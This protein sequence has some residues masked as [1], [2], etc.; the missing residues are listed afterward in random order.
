ML[1]NP[2]SLL[3]RITDLLYAPHLSVGRLLRIAPS[4][5][6][7]MENILY[8]KESSKE[9]DR[10]ETYDLKPSDYFFPERDVAG[11]ALA[12]QS[13]KDRLI[14]KFEDRIRV[15]A[16][17]RKELLEILET[18]TT[19]LE[20]ANAVD[21]SIFVVRFPVPN[22]PAATLKSRSSPWRTGLRSSDGKWIY[23]TVILDFFWAK[24]SL[25][26][27]AMDGLIKGYNIFDQ[28]GPMSI[29][30][31]PDEYKKRFMKMMGELVVEGE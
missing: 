16:S 11:G 28:K 10:W 27:K 24:D 21:Y 6:I 23:R 2:S 9:P 15:T 1:L 5:H 31:T 13:V 22:E 3:V 17:Q 25:Q 20:T 29:T 30:T 14:D 26:A 8:G 7:I 12:P 4:H 18:D 19:L